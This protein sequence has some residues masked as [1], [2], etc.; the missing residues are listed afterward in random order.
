MYPELRVPDAVPQAEGQ[1]E[2]SKLCLD[3]LGKAAGSAVGLYSCHGQGGNQQWVLTHDGLLQHEVRASV[4]G[5]EVAMGP[6]GVEPCWVGRSRAPRTVRCGARSP[7][8]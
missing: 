2:N 6:D 7:W 1:V 5:W 8:R 3:S 4:G